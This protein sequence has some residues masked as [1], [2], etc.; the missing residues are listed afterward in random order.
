MTPAAPVLAY[1]GVGANLDA[2]REQVRAAIAALRALPGGAVDAVSSLYASAPV[3]ASGPDYVNAVVALRTSRP[4]LDLLHAL[5][6]IEAR[7][8]RVRST[9]NAP[10]PL[11]LDLLLYGDAQAHTVQ[12][13][14]PH[15]RLHQRAFVLRPLLE[16]APNLQL[17]GLG[18]L[19]PWL[20]RA[21]DQRVHRI[22]PAP[23]PT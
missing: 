22:E 11:D 23:A 8:G 20:E 6:A 2:P 15:P 9:P 4:A 10:R 14:L 17:P 12:L 21:Q 1:I 5:Q 3:D 7:A 18:A 16:I 19:A 13:T